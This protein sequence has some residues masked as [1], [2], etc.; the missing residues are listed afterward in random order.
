LLSLGA[1]IE[2]LVGDSGGS[3]M[4]PPHVADFAWLRSEHFQ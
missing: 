3:H 1:L 4:P 2:F